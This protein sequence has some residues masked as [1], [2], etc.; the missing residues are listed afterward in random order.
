MI[1]LGDRLPELTLWEGPGVSRTLRE[2]CPGATLLIFL[3]HLA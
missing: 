3:R 1:P 2:L